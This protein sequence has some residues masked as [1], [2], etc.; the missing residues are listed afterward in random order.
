MDLYGIAALMGASKA[1][2]QANKDIRPFAARPFSR[3]YMLHGTLTY[4]G[5]STVAGATITSL[6]RSFTA[7]RQIRFSLA[8]TNNGTFTIFY[9]IDG[10]N[11]KSEVVTATQDASTSKWIY[12]K[13]I[14]GPIMFAY[15]TYKELASAGIVFGGILSQE[16]VVI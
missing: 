15:Y 13:A 2:I 11:Y 3:F 4:E 8:S 10:V 14:S 1:L 6:K 12:E 9:S 5:I 7:S 16:D